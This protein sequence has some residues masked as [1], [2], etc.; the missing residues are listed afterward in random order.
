MSKQPRNCLVIPVYKNAGSLP[1]LM[2]EVETIHRGVAG[3][4]EATF[5]VDGSPDNSLTLLRS[6]LPGQEFPSQL[7]ALSRNFGSFAAI[8]AGLASAD[9]G[10]YA[11]MAADLQDPPE[12]VC[13]F[14]DIL[15]ADQC[16]VV[17]GQREG[18]ADPFGK[19]ISS[20]LFWWLYNKI[21]NPEMPK[22]GID[23]FGCTRAVR[24]EVLRLEEIRSSLVGLLVWVGYRRQGVPYHRRLRTEGKSG[25]SL[26]RRFR[27]MLDSTF[28]FS[29]APIHL[30]V[31]SGAIIFVLSVIY[32]L[33]LFFLSFR[34]L[35]GDARGFPTLAGL[36]VVFGSINMIAI[37][38][39]GQY[40]WRS[41]ENT[42]HRPHYIVREK[43]KYDNNM[44]SIDC[45][46]HTKYPRETCNK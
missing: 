6:L 31:A 18:R 14:Y 17:Y 11:V 33:L 36:V 22:G 26:R 8:R 10:L 27:Y 20:A 24:D 23:I 43:I 7:I 15:Q 46:T 21:I 41:F 1:A 42:K 25:W 13:S 30:I 35:I 32:L 37:G 4:I 28:S 45:K 40:A 19:R 16:D 3:G 34:G 38:I 5:V 12:T 44:I 9:G 39:V 29:Q 2:K